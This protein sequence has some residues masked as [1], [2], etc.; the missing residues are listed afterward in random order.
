MDDKSGPY[1]LLCAADGLR[2][3]YKLA[4][5]NIGE[6][7][8]AAEL[9]DR[10]PVAGHTVIDAKLLR[11]E[12]ERLVVAHGARFLRPTARTSRTDTAASAPS[13]N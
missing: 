4:A 8:V 10:V 1:Q 3:A 7:I 12:L 13:V 9:L 6:R 2:I 11:P 5:A